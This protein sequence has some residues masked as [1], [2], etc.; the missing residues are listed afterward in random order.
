MSHSLRKLVITLF[1]SPCMFYRN[2]DADTTFD[3]LAGSSF[4]GISADTYYGA[5]SWWAGGPD[6]LMMQN[7]FYRVGSTG[8]EHYMGSLSLDS[9]NQPSSDQVILN[10]SLAGVFDMTVTYDLNDGSG[11]L[12]TEMYRTVNVENTSEEVLDFH[13]FDYTWVH[14]NNDSSEDSVSIENSTTAVQVDG[15]LISTITTDLEASHFE[16]GQDQSIYF[17][18]FDTSPTTLGDVTGPIGPGTLESAFEWDLSIPESGSQTITLHQTIELVPEPATFSLFGLGVL[19]CLWR[20][21]C[22]HGTETHS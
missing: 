20:M 8:G 10:Y 16:V 13:L 22:R 5:Y 17:A 21:C 3:L 15:A 7:F 14:L 18:L 19:V 11:N 6:Q 9:W 12:L 2:C 1:L 4:L